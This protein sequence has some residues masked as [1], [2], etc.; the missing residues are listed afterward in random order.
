MVV[1]ILAPRIM[2]IA[3]GSDISPALTKPIVITVVALLL[4]NTAVVKA[5]AS[6]PRIGFFVILQWEKCLSLGSI[7]QCPF[8]L[9]MGALVA[10][11]FLQALAHHIHAVN[12]NCQTSDQSE[13]NFHR[14][15]HL[16]FLPISFHKLYTPYTFFLRL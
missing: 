10:R 5:P 6:T 9:D 4:C 3:C 16:W 1:P 15:V 13:N 2:E 8:S 12:K 7:L 14:L 11:C